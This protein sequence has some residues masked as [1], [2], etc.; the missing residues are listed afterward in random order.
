MLADNRN[1]LNKNVLFKQ[2]QTQGEH[3]L[4]NSSEIK[5]KSIAYIC[6]IDNINYTHFCKLLAKNRHFPQAL[7]PFIRY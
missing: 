6:G 4:E 2:I 3:Q 1:K 7:L 5:I